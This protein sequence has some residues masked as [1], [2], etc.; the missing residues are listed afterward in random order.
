MKF[1]ISEKLDGISVSLKYENGKLIQALTR[2]D[3]N[4]GEDITRNV[5]KMK[6]VLHE[7]NE[8]FT[9]HIRG[10]IVLFHSDWKT[11]L[12]D[13]ANPRNAASGTAKR[14][15]GYKAQHLTVLVYNV[16][17]KDFDTEDESFQY[18]TSLGFKTPNYFVG[19]IQDVIDSW[20]KYMD[21][22]RETLDYDIDG[23][24]ISVNDRAK[25][26]ALGFEGNRP[27]GTIA[28]KFEAP[29]ART[30]LRKVI[31]QV[32]DTGRITPVGEFDPVELLGV[33]VER[34]SLHNVANIT[35]LGIKI[36]STILVSRRNDVIPYIEKVIV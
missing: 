16:N 21:K 1:L 4:V 12:S 8:D 13:K 22:T 17:G 32:G 29:E 6:G 30:I 7:L 25:Q 33:T 24:V 36:G 14:I 15:D 26:F 20:Q 31:W 11:H 28:F 9:G 27:K 18:M 2:G 10:E 19:T 23:L 34:A 5:K 35:K 3:G